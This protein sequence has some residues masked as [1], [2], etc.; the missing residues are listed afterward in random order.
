MSPLQRGRKE[1][2]EET[3]KAVYELMTCR[4]NVGNQAVLMKGV[5]DDV[6][7]FRE[8]HQKLLTI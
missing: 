2:V 1:I 8:L 4:I 7:T 6:E 3:A 5:N